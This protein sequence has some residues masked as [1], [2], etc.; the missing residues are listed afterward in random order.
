MTDEKIEILP[1]EGKFADVSNRLRAVRSYYNMT[2]T[3]FALQADVARK[4]YSQWE[5]GKLRISVD[6]ALSIARRYGIS[7]DFIY[8]GRLDALPNNIANALSSSPLLK[9]SKT[10]T[11]S[12]D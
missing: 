2:S 1:V 11:V 5:S 4:S 8:L 7:L 9:Y 6:G 12:P 10:S 3:E